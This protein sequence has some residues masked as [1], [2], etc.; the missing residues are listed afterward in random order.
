MIVCVALKRAVW[1]YARVDDLFRCGVLGDGFRA[2]AHSMFGQFSGEEKANGCLHLTAA[3]RRF[4]V[5]LRKA[6]CFVG[7][8]LENV[9]HEAVHN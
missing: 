5:V 2:L 1:G 7:D 9:V 6:R 3:D 4:L 8:A